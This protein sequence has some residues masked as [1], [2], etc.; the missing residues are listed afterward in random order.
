M[1]EAATAKRKVGAEA[2]G[3][4][5]EGEQGGS[6]RKLL[7]K[8]K[9]EIKDLQAEAKR[10]ASKAKGKGEKQQVEREF[11]HKEQDLLAEHQRQLAA[12]ANKAAAFG[13]D[14]EL[15]SGGGGDAHDQSNACGVAGASS[16]ESKQAKRGGG[17]PQ[18]VAGASP[19]SES[20]DAVVNAFESLRLYGGDEGAREPAKLSKAQQRRRKKRAEDE[21][22]EE[23][24]RREKEEADPDP[25]QVERESLQRSLESRGLAI[26]DIAADGH[27][28]YR[29]V[30]HQ[31]RLN[32][33]A[34]GAAFALEHPESWAV[35][36]LRGK[37]ADFLKDHKDDFQPFLDDSA[38]TDHGFADY[39][40]KIR[41]TAEWGGEVE[42]QVISK[43]IQRRIEVATIGDNEFMLLHYGEE[44]PSDESPLRLAFHRLLLA[45]GG[46]YNSVVPLG[47]A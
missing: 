16:G 44:F 35:E 4:E 41:S 33:S 15:P 34:G 2:S 25:G 20:A 3:S 39:C 27:C 10:A 24:L 38:Q 22:R 7:Q 18:A 19:P 9:K 32:P 28:L 14:G 5:S 40:E 30:C 45:A 8:H 1:T 46:H 36:T 11:K 12:L 26:H 6:R 17:V 43:V 47:S 42:L 13:D 23:A 21:E 31:L 29:A 37:V